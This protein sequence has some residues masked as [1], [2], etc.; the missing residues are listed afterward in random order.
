MAF[1]FRLP[2]Q[3]PKHW[4]VKIRDK[5]RNEVPHVTI[6]RKTK[7]WRINLCTGQFMDQKPDPSEVPKK[8][9]DLI[10]ENANWE[11]ICR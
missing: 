9:I 2:K 10:L 3:F 1:N 8:R 6:L 4:A 7:A 11:L 5:E